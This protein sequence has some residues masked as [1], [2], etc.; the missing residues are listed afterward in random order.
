MRH[1]C[2]DNGASL[3]AATYSSRTAV[4][5]HDRPDRGPAATGLR[6]DRPIL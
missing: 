4:K 2:S 6:D 3:T 5:S 1:V